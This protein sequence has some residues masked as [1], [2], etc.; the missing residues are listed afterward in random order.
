M[1]KQ[2]MRKLAP[3]HFGEELRI[4]PDDSRQTAF[5]RHC[6]QP[7]PD[8]ARTNFAKMQM[9][10]KARRAGQVWPVPFYRI[11]VKRCGQKFLQMPRRTGFTG[12]PGA[13]QSAGPVESWLQRQFIERE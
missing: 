13:L 1:K 3:A 12:L 8:L 6:F 2:V 4:P 7:V 5:R 11:V 9:R 10:R